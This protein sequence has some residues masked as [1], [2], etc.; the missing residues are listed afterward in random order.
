MIAMAQAGL[1]LPHLSLFE[2]YLLLASEGHASWGQGERGMAGAFFLEA[3]RDTGTRHPHRRYL[4]PGY[5][6][7]YVHTCTVHTPVSVT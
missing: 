4:G 1:G 3:S 2:S 6:S 5:A 7:M